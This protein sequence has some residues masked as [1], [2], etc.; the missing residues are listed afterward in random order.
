MQPSLHFVVGGR[1]LRVFDTVPTSNAREAPSFIRYNP[2]FS[3]F[4]VSMGKAVVEFDARTG[5]EKNNSFEV[6][7]CMRMCAYVRMRMCTCMRVS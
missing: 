2:H 6:R 3:S 1:G 5:L 7:T 4:L